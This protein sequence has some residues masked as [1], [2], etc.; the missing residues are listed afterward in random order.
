MVRLLLRRGWNQIHAKF[1]QS[2]KLCFVGF[3]IHVIQDVPFVSRFLVWTLLLF[4]WACISHQRVNLVAKAHSYSLDMLKWNVIS[5]WEVFFSSNSQSPPTCS[6]GSW[7][8]GW[9]SFQE[10]TKLEFYKEFLV[11]GAPHHPTQR[12][13]TEQESDYGNSYHWKIKLQFNHLLLISFLYWILIH[14]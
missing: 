11:W 13:I 3:V 6:N 14:F 9:V 12:R 7:T 4:L 1:P 10:L 5:P 8:R 2:K